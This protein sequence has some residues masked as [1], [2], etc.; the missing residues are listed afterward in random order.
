MLCNN[1]QPL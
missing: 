1:V